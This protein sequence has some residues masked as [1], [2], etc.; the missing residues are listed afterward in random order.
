MSEA[1]SKSSAMVWAGKAAIASA[2]HLYD[3]CDEI[4]WRL[5]NEHRYRGIG[6]T[7]IHAVVDAIRTEA[8]TWN[9]VP[10]LKN[11][12]TVDWVGVLKDIHHGAMSEFIK[13]PYGV[14]FMD[15]G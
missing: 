6:R 7:E 10:Y 8:I 1:V 14:L 4:Q 15:C 3:D 5:E 13:T 11:N 9:L 2:P 12:G